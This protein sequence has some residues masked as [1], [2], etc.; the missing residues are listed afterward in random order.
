MTFLLTDANS[1]PIGGGNGQFV[2]D[3]DGKI[4]VD[5]LV[6]GTAVVAREIRTVKGY[7]LNGTPQTIE[8]TANGA[9]AASGGRSQTTVAAA[10]AGNSLTF[11]D[12]PLSTLVVHKYIAG[13]RNEPLPGVTFKVTDSSGKVVGPNDGVY[14]SDENGAFVVKDLEPGITVKVQET[15]TVAGYELDGTPKDI[16]I[17][18]ASVQELTFRNRKLGTLVIKAQDSA[19]KEPIPGVFVS[20]TR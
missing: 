4:V 13:T 10:S 12:N 14:V 16:V 18:E 7:T 15:A 9:V 8:I 2:T 11:Y 6:P 20:T 17:K 19:T 1:N 3:G 5:G